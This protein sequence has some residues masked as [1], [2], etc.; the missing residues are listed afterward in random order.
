[1]ILQNKSRQYFKNFKIIKKNNKKTKI[2]S[3]RKNTL[4]K[5]ENDYRIFP[6]LKYMKSLIEK[7]NI[8]NL[9]KGIFSSKYAD[10]LLKKIELFLFFYF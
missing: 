3:Q 10:E 7:K 1:M 2:I 4:K 6:V 8:N 9:K 5:N